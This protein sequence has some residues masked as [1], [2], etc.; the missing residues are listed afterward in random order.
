MA[1]LVFVMYK[2]KWNWILIVKKDIFVCYDKQNPAYLIYF[3]ETTA[4]KRFRCV[5]F[6]KSY[7]NSSLLK[8]HKNT[9]I[10]EYIITYDV[11]SKDNLNTEG[12][13][14]ITCYPIQKR[15][16]SIFLSKILNLV[17]LITVVVWI[18]SL[19]NCI[20]ITGF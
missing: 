15:K 14:Q 16:D 2:I 9:E 11:Q 20:W 12:E 7:D 10:L 6:N 13:G 17:G 8:P 1:Q 19:L 4:I 3:S 5:K 18:R